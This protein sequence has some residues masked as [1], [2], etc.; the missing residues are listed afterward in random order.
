MARAV[1][2]YDKELPEIPGRLSWEK[3]SHHLVKDDGAATGWRVE[4]GRR[5]SQI[6]LV[7]M[8]LATRG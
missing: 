6:L 8:L 5:E 4:G 7:P 2:A 1:I 3:P